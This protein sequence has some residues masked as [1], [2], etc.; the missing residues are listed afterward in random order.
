[1]SQKRKKFKRIWVRDKGKCGIHLGGCGKDVTLGEA[2]IG[3]I[4]PKALGGKEPDEYIPRRVRSE[5]TKQKGIRLPINLNIQPMHRKCNEAMAATFPFVP[6]RQWCSCCKWIYATK[7]WGDRV[8]PIEPWMGKVLP[9]GRGKKFMLLRVMEMEEEGVDKMII[10]IDLGPTIRIEYT[11]GSKSEAIVLIAGRTKD[12]K[13]G[14]WEGMGSMNITMRVMQEHNM[15]YS[16]HELADAYARMVVA[17]ERDHVRKP[18]RP[19]GE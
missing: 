5:M 11:D 9:E 1:M 14:A 15:R 3:H 12:G 18:R 7:D 10:G 2:E 8:R 16:V 6:M 4:V 19:D 17:T 13:Q